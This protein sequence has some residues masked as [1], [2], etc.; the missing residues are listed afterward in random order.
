MSR[1]R[2]SSGFPLME[3]MLSLAGHVLAGGLI[4]VN[5]AASDP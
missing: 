1:G 5:G 2:F 3:L 4:V